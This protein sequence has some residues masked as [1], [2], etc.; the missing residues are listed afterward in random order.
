MKAFAICL[1]IALAACTRP[2]PVPLQR[3]LSPSHRQEIAL[4]REEAGGTLDSNT[5]LTIA[6]AGAPF[7][8]DNIFAGIKR[9]RDV[10]S[11]WSTTGKPVL[12]IRDFD[13]F[14]ASKN[15]MDAFI[16]CGLSVN[17][18]RRL[19]PPSAP[20]SVIKLGTYHTGES[21]PFTD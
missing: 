5:Y 12:S 14:A 1:F 19:L 16:I 6:E 13:G 4:W 8:A 15:G 18:C 7:S 17:V 10:E 21:E 9:G 11:Y 2:P 3:L 20:T